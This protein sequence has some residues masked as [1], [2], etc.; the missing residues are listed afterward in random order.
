MALL[1]T[2]IHLGM[3]DSTM[4]SAWAIAKEQDFLLVTAEGQTRGK[5]TRGRVWQSPKGNVYMTVGINRRHLPPERLALLPLE[6]GILLWEEAAGRLDDSSR[7]S[8]FLKWPNDLVMA[9]A[10]AAGILM[11]SHGDF[12]LC[13]AGIN[14]AEAPRVEDG[15]AATAC[16]SRGGMPATDSQ[17]SSGPSS[18]R[19]LPSPAARHGAF[20]PCV[21]AGRR[22]VPAP[23]TWEWGPEKIT[24]GLE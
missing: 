2:E 20:G 12:L 14:V 11:E 18:R 8:L 15:G 3:V 1:T 17:A 5:G 19:F 6:I 10:K 13:G 9:G 4:E 22:P 24:G 7:K 16:L 23:V 21:A